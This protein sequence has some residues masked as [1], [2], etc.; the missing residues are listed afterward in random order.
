MQW[1][2]A[3]SFLHGM[4][5]LP[6]VQPLPGSRYHLNLT[7]IMAIGQGYT[8]MTRDLF[9]TMSETIVAIHRYISDARPLLEWPNGSLMDTHLKPYGF[10][11]RGQIS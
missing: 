3:P 7:P 2:C 10:D 4:C 11:V 8:D 9:T 5:Q 1:Q 6:L